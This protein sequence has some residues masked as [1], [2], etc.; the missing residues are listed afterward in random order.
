MLWDDS[1]HAGF[2]TGTPWFDV[3]PNYTEI[4]A[5]AAR[6]DPRS[7]FAHYQKLIQL[8]HDDEAVREGRFQLL[9]PDH[10]Q[11][12]AFTRTLDEQTPPQ[13]PEGSSASEI[14]SKGEGRLLVIANC[15]SG[16]GQ[17]PTDDLPSLDG[18][19]LVLGTRDD[20]DPAT[21]AAWES[22]ILRLA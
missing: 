12:W 21:L 10:D 14:V 3:N 2:T 16:P 19:E 5:E 17:I 8:R 1:E 22:R 7:V 13:V 20:A 4:N 15:S 6:R 9:L 18:A 11:L